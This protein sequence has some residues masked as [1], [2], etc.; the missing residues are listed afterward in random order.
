[1]VS[2]SLLRH[3]VILTPAGHASRMRY[4]RFRQQMEGHV[5]TRRPRAA[6][7]KRIVRKG[8]KQ[9]DNKDQV[10][11]KTEHAASVVEQNQ[12]SS[13]AASS[14]DPSHGS[15]ANTTPEPAMVKP[16]PEE[17]LLAGQLPLPSYQF[18][19]AHMPREMRETTPAPRG[20][21]SMNDYDNMEEFGLGGNHFHGHYQP[22][23]YSTMMDGI[24]DP[25]YTHAMDPARQDAFTCTM[26][27]QPDGKV[28]GNDGHVLVKAEERWDQSYLSCT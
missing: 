20:F 11:I 5:P 6:G 9:E 10:K 17:D 16:E 26:G 8:T 2:V 27:M 24:I 4:S 18:G 19:P 15:T 23:V 12:R 3:H 1:M 25:S 22:G 14:I 7:Q 13:P 28:S 21:D